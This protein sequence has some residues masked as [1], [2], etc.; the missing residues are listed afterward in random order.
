MRENR[1]IREVRGTKEVKNQRNNEIPNDI[2]I[3]EAILYGLKIN[4][5]Y[6]TKLI[7]LGFTIYRLLVWAKDMT[8][9][10]F[11]VFLLVDFV[12]YGYQISHQDD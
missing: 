2:T 8:M 6:Y 4:R 10:N 3:F 12:L 7:I 9:Y 11:I 1:K 5:V